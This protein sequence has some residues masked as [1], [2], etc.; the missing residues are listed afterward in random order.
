MPRLHFDNAFEGWSQFAEK[1]CFNEGRSSSS[2]HTLPASL[3]QSHC[4]PVAFTSMSK[5]V[6]I[7]DSKSME[8]ARAI[9]GK[10]NASSTESLDDVR[11]DIIRDLQSKGAVVDEAEEQ[12]PPPRPRPVP[13]PRFCRERDYSTLCPQDWLVG[14]DSRTGRPS[15]CLAPLGFVP[16]Q[17]CPTQFS[18]PRTTKEKRRL[19][20]QCAIMWPCSERNNA[21]INREIDEDGDFD[22]GK[23]DLSVPCPDGWGYFSDGSCRAPH[24]Y[25]GPCLKKMHFLGYTRSM[26][27]QWARQC[28]ANW[29]MLVTNQKQRWRREFRKFGPPLWPRQCN[30]DYAA[31]C[32][33]GWKLAE[34]GWCHAPYA[35]ASEPSPHLVAFKLDDP[36]TCPDRIKTSRFS[37]RMKAALSKHC[38]VDW[39]CQGESNTVTAATLAEAS[40]APALVPAKTVTLSTV[41][42]M[43]LIGLE[44]GMFFL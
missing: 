34:T 35:S 30:R 33:A 15:S 18:G 39:P 37:A 25:S 29:P 5:T 2:S 41:P 42:A 38:G 43:Y 40:G 11:A 13:T 14:T 10:L 7:N 9:V 6:S 32:P 28:N 19:E 24:R 27:A 22:G 4:K 44:V 8:S 20:D 21:S 23:R 31:P 17:G 16:A 12:L 26:K 3:I 36:K 1:A